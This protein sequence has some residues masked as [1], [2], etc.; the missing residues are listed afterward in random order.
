MEEDSAAHKLI[1]L[2][3]ADGWRATELLPKH[4][5]ATGGNFSVRYLAENADGRRGFL[6]ALNYSAAF[7]PDIDTPRALEFMTSA[8]NF[9]KEILDRCSARRMRR[10]VTAVSNGSVAVPNSGPYS[11]VD[12]LIFDRA[13][14]DLRIYLDLAEVFDVA[15]RLRALHH[16]TTGLR[17]LHA[18]QIAHQD[19][20]PSNLLIFPED[21]TKIADLG[22]ASRSGH[23]SPYD[24]FPIPGDPGYSSP[25][26]LY[27]EVSSDFGER[28]LAP[29]LYMLGSLAYFLFTSMNLTSTLLAELHPAH[30]PKRWFDGYS[31]ALPY[32][33]EAFDRAMKTLEAACETV[34]SRT[35]AGELT[36]VVRELCDPDAKRRGDPK[37][38]GR[39]GNPYSL[40]RYVTR[41]N[42]LASQ[43]ELKLAQD[44]PSL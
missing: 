10:V 14:N 30:H 15:W 24:E 20:K 5:R 16:A 19:L 23:T 39:H 41:F 29:D 26:L 35:R 33:R 8:F 21:G 12:Y 6:K 17:Q 25:E 11:R 44:E 4:E 40:E 22:Q 42:V 43:M 7:E 27:G 37:S 13:E 2:E 28:R 32:V 31:Q 3:L 34:M 36:T 1:G 9:E 18:E 38:K